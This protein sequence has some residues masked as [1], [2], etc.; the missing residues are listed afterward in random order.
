MGYVFETKS[1]TH[2][3]DKTT[4]MAVMQVGTWQD[5]YKEFGLGLAVNDGKFLT[6]V[7]DRFYN[8]KTCGRALDFCELDECPRD[9]VVL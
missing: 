2:P 5:I 4:D 6:K 1:I 7:N 8:C 9:G 3:D